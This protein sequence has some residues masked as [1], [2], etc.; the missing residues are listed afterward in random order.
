MGGCDG[1][2]KDAISRRTIRTYSVGTVGLSLKTIRLGRREPLPNHDR[3]SHTVSLVSPR[4]T[5]RERERVRLCNPFSFLLVLSVA[6][7]VCATDFTEVVWWCQALR[8]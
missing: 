7:A 8:L 3:L 1:I 2:W 4:N 5:E 6:A